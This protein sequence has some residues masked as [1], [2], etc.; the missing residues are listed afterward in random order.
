MFKLLDGALFRQYVVV[1]ALNLN[2]LAYGLGSNW[3]SPVL[4][5]L[6]DPT[7]TILPK[8]LDPTE[9]SW[10]VS[11]YFLLGAA[12]YLVAFTLVDVIG[13]KKCVLLSSVIKLVS[14][15]LFLFGNDVWML[16]LGRAVIGTADGIILCVI[17]V[18]ASEIASKEVRGALGTMLQ[19]FSSIGTVIMLSVGPFISYFELNLMLMLLVLATSIPTLFLPDSPNFLFSKVGPEASKNVLIFLRGSEHRADED[20]KEYAANRTDEK[21]SLRIIFRNKLFQKSLAMTEFIFIMV[22]LTGFNS[23]TSYLQTILDTTQTNVRSEVASGIIGAINVV[24]SLSTLM[25]TDKF[26]R[27]PILVSTLFGM[28]VG[29]VGLGTFFKLTRD[30]TEIS[31]FLNFL[32]LLSLLLIVFCYSAGTGSLVWLLITELYDDRSRGVGVASTLL[33]AAVPSFLCV[34]YFTALIDAIGPTPTFWI[35]AAFC[36]ILAMFVAFKLPETKGKSFTEIQHELG[37]KDKL[38]ST[39]I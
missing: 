2:F 12:G 11:I 38:T 6:A 4:V 5:K 18:Y 32:P 33:L 35:S 39:R 27:K 23:V 21:V 28:T 29:M 24:A 31:G 37:N 3:P 22:L 15:L 26:G 20:I 30:E 34:R 17:P 14:A 10:I 36:V 19:V 9:A 1:F 16:M 7:E 25:T 8:P 13:R